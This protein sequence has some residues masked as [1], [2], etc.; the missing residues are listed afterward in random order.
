M[1]SLCQVVGHLGA[2]ELAASAL[3][4]SL[5]NVLGVSLIWGL[6]SGLATLCGQVSLSM[7]GCLYWLVFAAHLHILYSAACRA[8][9]FQ[10]S[11]TSDLLTP[12]HQGSLNLAPSTGHSNDY[13]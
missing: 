9:Q 3:A 5:A 12:D 11:Q 6:S 1:H 8:D 2:A 10:P 7:G 4:M 13:M